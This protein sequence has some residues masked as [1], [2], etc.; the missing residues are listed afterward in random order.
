MRVLAVVLA[1]IVCWSAPA[2]AE[3]PTVAR[4]DILWAG[5]YEAQ[6]GATITQP[7][8]A[9]GRTNELFNTKKLRATTTVEGRLRQLRPR[10][11]PDRRAGGC[12][13]ADHHRRQAA[14]GGPKIRPRV[15]A[16]IASSGCRRPSRSA[17]ATWSAIPSSTPGRWCPACGASRSGRTIRNSASNPSASWPKR[18]TEADKKEPAG[19]CRRCSSDPLPSAEAVEARRGR[20][21]SPFDEF[22]AGGGALTA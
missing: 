22:R 7:D 18:A 20:A 14:Q 8:T 2:C 6:M 17:A 5:L 11:R 13:C 21:H 3:P 10:V 16:S 9:A 4:A 1:L 15:N 19:P 12:R